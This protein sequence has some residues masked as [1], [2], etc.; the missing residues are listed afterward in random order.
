MAKAKRKTLPKDF[1]AL[2]REGDIDALKAALSLC[3]PDARGGYSKQ[4]AL[5]FNAWSCR[6]ETFQAMN[7]TVQFIRAFRQAA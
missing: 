4:T 5:A 7:L 3:E 1:E 6:D 2:L